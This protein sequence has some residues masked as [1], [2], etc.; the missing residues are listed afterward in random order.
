VFGS[1][2]SALGASSQ[3]HVPAVLSSLKRSPPPRVQETGW[4][5]QAV[6]LRGG[7]NAAVLEVVP[8]QVNDKWAY[9]NE[10]RL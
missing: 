8:P 3:L 5:P 7:E 9:N 1:G 6:R 2:T 10:T 4:T